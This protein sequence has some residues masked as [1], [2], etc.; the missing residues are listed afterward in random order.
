M[1]TN[2]FKGRWNQLKGEIQRQWGRFTND[3]LLEIKGDYTK[4]TGLVQKRYGDQQEVVKKW[5]ERWI[6]EHPLEEPE[7]RAS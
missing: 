7:R 1:N 2:Q 5:V 6:D 4:F 3:D